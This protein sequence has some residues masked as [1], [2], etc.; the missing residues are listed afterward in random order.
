MNKHEDALRKLITADVVT[1]NQVKR[2]TGLDLEEVS[3]EMKKVATLLHT[4]TC[5][6]CGRV[7]NFIEESTFADEWS[8]PSHKAWIE[9]A[10]GIST[11]YNLSD[12]QTLAVVT[13]AVGCMQG[14][15]TL[16]EPTLDLLITFLKAHLVQ[17]RKAAT[18][19]KHKDDQ[20]DGS[21]EGSSPQETH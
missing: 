5:H 11:Q 19:P 3:E 1:V 4:M 13:R 12:A 7:C 2:I 17:V 18:A 20:G 14:M 9:T 15:T 16:T 10:K 6:D 21:E 8:K